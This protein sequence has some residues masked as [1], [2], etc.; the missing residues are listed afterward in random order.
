MPA[1]IFQDPARV[2]IRMERSDKQRLEAE[3][4]KQD[5]PLADYCRH[6]LKPWPRSVLAIVTLPLSLRK[7]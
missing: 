1:K 4:K 2:T 6:R 3:A 7:H 5:I